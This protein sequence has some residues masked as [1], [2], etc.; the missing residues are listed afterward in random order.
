MPRI[1]PVASHNHDL[2]NAF[3]T[4]ASAPVELDGYLALSKSPS[5]GRMSAR[6]PEILALA[7][8]QENECPILPLRHRRS[9]STWF[10]SRRYAQGP[11]RQQQRSLR[12]RFGLFDKKHRS[13]AR[14]CIRTGV[15]HRAEGWNR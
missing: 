3:A 1:T 11:L 5:R 7:I 8:A 2:S 10:E 4:L 15:G 12:I 9:K 6:Q 14:S 13:S